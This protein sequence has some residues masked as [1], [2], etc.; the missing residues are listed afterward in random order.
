M[1][2]PHVLAKF[3][4]W[5]AILHFTQHMKIANFTGDIMTKHLGLNRNV[6]QTSYKVFYASNRANLLLSSRKV[7][8]NIIRPSHL[9]SNKWLITK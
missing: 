6:L 4:E 8:K 7:A 2:S 9:M 5:L 1:I 3:V